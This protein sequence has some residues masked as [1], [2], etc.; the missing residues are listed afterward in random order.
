[1]DAP[2]CDRS[3]G[4]VF[5]ASLRRRGARVV[6]SHLAIVRLH[7]RADDLVDLRGHEPG[8]DALAGGGERARAARELAKHRGAIWR[9]TPQVT[10]AR[11]IR[12]PKNVQTPG[13]RAARASIAMST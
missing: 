12:A 9:A 1:M 7:R 10:P 8:G 4:F 11:A 3:V 6:A 2:R 13:K 5:F